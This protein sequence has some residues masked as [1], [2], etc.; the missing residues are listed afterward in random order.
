M[1]DVIPVG[2]V[3]S[4]MFPTRVDDGVPLV[5]VGCHQHFC[6]INPTDTEIVVLI[7]FKMNCVEL[8]VITS[9]KWVESFADD[10]MFQSI[11]YPARRMQDAQVIHA[12]DIFNLMRAWKCIK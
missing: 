11:Q 12:E 9:V 10:V 6:I 7:M 2:I 5:D 8:P 1:T 4:R 3:L